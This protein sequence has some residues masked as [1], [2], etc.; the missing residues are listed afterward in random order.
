[1]IE[2]VREWLTSLV[3]AAMLVTVAQSLIQPGTIRQIASFIGGLILLAVLL[4]P[5]LASDL[6]GFEVDFT[7]W[8]ATVEER[9]AELRREQGEE[10]AAIIEERTEAYISDKAGELGL[11]VHARVETRAG[12]DGV[13][14]PWS[15]ELTGERSAE[16]AACLTEDLGIPAERQVW[17]E[18]ETED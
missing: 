6:L 3:L 18:R 16:L 1:M 12:N 4:R 2:A 7:A 17:H 9:E 14:V 10:L 8:Q 13:P 11:A 5:I 15:A